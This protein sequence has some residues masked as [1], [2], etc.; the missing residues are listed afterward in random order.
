MNAVN[1]H[2]FKYVIRTHDHK[3]RKYLSLKLD[4]KYLLFY[5]TKCINNLQI[6]YK[7]YVH[8]KKVLNFWFIIRTASKVIAVWNFDLRIFSVYGRGARSYIHYHSFSIININENQWD[9]SY[10]FLFAQYVDYKTILL[11]FLKICIYLIKSS[12]HERQYW[13]CRFV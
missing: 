3:L 5:M 13:P 6:I 9:W 8:L 11:N 2:Q 10:I 1:K 7:E 4:S 12:G